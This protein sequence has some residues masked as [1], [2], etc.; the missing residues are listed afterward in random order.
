[1]DNFWK[2][3]PRPFFALAPMEDVTDTVFRE[4]VATVSSPERLHVLFTEFT[5]I[6]GYL[7]E[8]GRER[9]GERLEVTRQERDLL[10]RKGIRL[11]AQVW[12]TDPDLFY[13]AGRRIAV[14][15]DFDGIDI[16]MG[17]PVKK[18]VR[19]GAC[20]A[21]IGNPR[22]AKEIIASTKEG[23]GLPVSVKT[24]TGNNRPATEDWIG[25]LLLARPAAITI[26]GR[27]RKMM[28]EGKADWDEIG[29]AVLARD[30]LGAD[31]LILGNGDVTSYPEGL[32]KA[33]GIGVDGIMVGRGIFSDPFFFS[34]DGSCSNEMKLRLLQFH[35]TRFDRVWEGRKNY[36]MLK[37]FFRIYVNRFDGASVLRAR[38]MESRNARLALSIL[39]PYFIKDRMAVL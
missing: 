12:G 28:S 25:Q 19:Q 34:G 16:N 31:T 8:R 6:N 22:L 7:H 17:C 39:E 10:K 18:I 37:R 30:S 32:Q 1:M 20:S 3:L 29:K 26:H 38:L 9:A 24:R 5:S 27:T 33:A 13:R 14:E 36:A 4:V 21:L 15:Y 2:Q 35:I 23:S 11:V